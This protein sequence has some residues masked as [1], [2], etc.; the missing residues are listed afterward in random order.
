MRR[1]SVVSYLNSLPY[2]EGLSRFL[3][4]DRWQISQDA[5]GEIARKLSLGMTDVGL[6]PVAAIP[7]IP[8]AKIITSCGIAANGPVNSV[9][10][11]S[12]R[13]V[14]ELKMVYLDFESRTSVALFKLL[15]R[16][17]WNIKPNFLSASHGYEREITG[18]TGGVVIGDRA[19][20]IRDSFE[21]RYDLSEIWKEMT[22]LPFVFAR[23]V[24]TIDLEHSES[25]E[26][27]N[28]LEQGLKCKNEV[29]GR[30][31]AEGNWS[32]EFIHKYLNESILYRIGDSEE[33]G[34]QHFIRN[35]GDFF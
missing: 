21:F 28:A 13:P 34:M 12:R 6:V 29:V 9:F 17:F 27:N 7:K 18:E 4:P 10:L 1:I 26:F 14:S 25:L 31:V 30:L 24:S 5:P 22:G 15:A 33:S 16:D 8:G 19:I 23:W 11:F 2:M 3:S 35:A 32:K 20:L